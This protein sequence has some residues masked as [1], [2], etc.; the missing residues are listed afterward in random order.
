MT[1]SPASLRLGIGSPVSI[2]SSTAELPSTTTPSTG[3]F[4][5]GRTRDEVAGENGGDRHVH[6]AAVAH[7]AGR[8]RLQPDE[9]AHGVAGLALGARL[10]QAA[11]EDQR[12]DERGGV[13]VHRLA[14]A[15]VLERLREEHAGDAVQ[16]GRRGAHGDQRVH[17]RAEAVAQAGPRG[18]VELPAHPEL[19]RRRQRPEHVAVVQPV[20]EKGEP[21]RLHRSY[22][23]ERAE[24]EAGDHLA[25]QGA[26]G[27]GA[28]RLLGVERRPRPRAGRARGF[29]AGRR[30]GDVVPG[31]AHRRHEGAVVGASRAGR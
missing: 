17:V 6:L 25:P 12:D 27:G 8:A 28:R 9:L 30:L 23:D 31:G 7:D 4:S 26:V 14:E 21:V 29:A 15:G 22:E 3:T 11:E 19:H 24:D 10:E 18:R 5:P 13:E 20:R 1:S 2:D 16:V